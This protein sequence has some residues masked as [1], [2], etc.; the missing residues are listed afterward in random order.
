MYGIVL[1]VDGKV[2]NQEVNMDLTMNEKLDQGHEGS[3]ESAKELFTLS[4]EGVCQAE[5]LPRIK[6]LRYS[7]VWNV[8]KQQ[9]H[10][11]WGIEVD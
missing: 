10:Q 1:V 4:R 5:R 2:E 6:D 3:E 8:K 7:G 11:G 9:G